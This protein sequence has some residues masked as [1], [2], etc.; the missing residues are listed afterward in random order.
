MKKGVKIGILEEWN[1]VSG[2]RN[3][4]FH[5]SNIPSSASSVPSLKTM[6]LF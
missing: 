4:I 3:P 1:D 5:D 6:V 2:K